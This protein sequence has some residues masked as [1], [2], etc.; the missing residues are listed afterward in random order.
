[1]GHPFGPPCFLAILAKLLS[2][3][4][5]PRHPGPLGQEGA[6]APPG[7]GPDPPKVSQAQRAASSSSQ[8]FSSPTFSGKRRR[9]RK[10][11]PSLTGAHSLSPRR[12]KP[13]Y[14][15]TARPY[16]AMP[17]FSPSLRTSTSTLKGEAPPSPALPNKADSSSQSLSSEPPA[18]QPL[19]ARHQKRRCPRT[20]VARTTLTGSASLGSTPPPKRG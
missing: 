5:L 12:G 8:K 15:W 11:T 14:H 6:K 16:W 1:M 7:P 2:D 13:R 17:T 18:R 19:T 9:R 4:L 20:A 10:A 3:L